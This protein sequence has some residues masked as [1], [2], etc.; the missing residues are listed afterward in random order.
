MGSVIGAHLGVFMIGN[1]RSKSNR[2]Q[3]TVKVRKVL[4]SYIGYYSGGKKK[5]KKKC[6]GN[7]SLFSFLM[8]ISY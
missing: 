8:H 7:W 4:E 5:E 1:I 6:T 3:N 2:V